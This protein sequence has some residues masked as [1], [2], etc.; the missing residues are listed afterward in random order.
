VRYYEWWAAA[1][2][3]DG[4]GL[5]TILHGWESGLDASP[6]YDGAYN[7]HNPQPALSELYPKFTELIL[8]YKFKCVCCLGHPSVAAAAAV[9]KPSVMCSALRGWLLLLIKLL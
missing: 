3:V 8:E 6:L 4:D 9:M 1:R 5:V 7:V 2:D